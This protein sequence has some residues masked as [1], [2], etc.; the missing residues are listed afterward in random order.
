[1]PVLVLGSPND[2]IASE[3]QIQRFY[4][5]IGS[6]DKTMHWYR[7]SYHLLL[8]DVQR[9]EVLHDATTWLETHLKAVQA[10]G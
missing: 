3:A 7:Q 9:E 2:V 6:R 10:P 4:N 1:M 5:Q 8:H